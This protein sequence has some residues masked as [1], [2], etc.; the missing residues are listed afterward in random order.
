MI[1]SAELLSPGKIYTESYDP[2]IA[3]CKAENASPIKMHIVGSSTQSPNIP[4]KG[5]SD[6][7]NLS[8]S[9]S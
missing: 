3:S 1:A 2:S 9:A 5:F 7:E 6:Y 4:G 8:D